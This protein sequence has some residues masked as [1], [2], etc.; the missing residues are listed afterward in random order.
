MQTMVFYGNKIMLMGPTAQGTQASDSINIM[1]PAGA[2]FVSGFAVGSLTVNGTDVFDNFGGVG[3]LKTCASTCPPFP[4]Y[5][6]VKGPGLFQYSITAGIPMLAGQS[7]VLDP[8]AEVTFDTPPMPPMPEPAS[9]T[10]ILVGFGALGA[11][12][13]ARRTP[14][15]LAG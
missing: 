2:T 14:R 8:T 9:W 7:A 4:E 5:N 12:M 11:A 6:T 1:L 10:M 3:G 15:R 13:R